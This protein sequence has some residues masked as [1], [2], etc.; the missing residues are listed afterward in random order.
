MMEPFPIIIKVLNLIAQEEEQWPMGFALAFD[1]LACLINFSSN[2][3]SQVYSA[4]ITYG[5]G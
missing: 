2:Q 4:T 3:F 1:F 5:R